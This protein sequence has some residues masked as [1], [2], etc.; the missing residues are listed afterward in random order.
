M[1]QLLALLPLCLS[2]P[3]LEVV[4]D[5]SNLPRLPI[6]WPNS[7]WAALHS[8]KKASVIGIKVQRGRIFLT[9]PPLARQLPPSQPC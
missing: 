7:S 5:W 4:F 2:S 3:S 6:A 9:L 1:L 8:D